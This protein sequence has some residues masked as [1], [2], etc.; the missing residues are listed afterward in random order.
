MFRNFF[1]VFILFTLI[2]VG[3]LVNRYKIKQ[4]ANKQLEEKNQLIEHQKD[5]VEQ[6]Q[7]EILDSIQ[8]ARR[9]QQSLLPNDKYIGRVLG[10]LKERK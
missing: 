9:I 4:R 7:K 1:L 6:K 8:Y 10:Q 5:L 2:F 3:I